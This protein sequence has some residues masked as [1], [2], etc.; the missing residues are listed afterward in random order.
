VG[1]GGTGEAIYHGQGGPAER[2]D[3]D[4]ANF[5]TRQV[6]PVVSRWL[7]ESDAPLVL[8]CVDRLAPIYR[9]ANTY[10][11]LIDG[12][13]SGSPAERSDDEL[14]ERAWQVVAPTLQ[15]I[16]KDARRKFEDLAGSDRTS[17]TAQRILEAAS[18][19]R[20]ETLFVSADVATAPNARHN[21]EGIV[22]RSAS[23]VEE[24]TVGTI[25]HG[26]QVLAVDQPPGSSLLAAVFRY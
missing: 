25:R 24:A 16:E 11:H 7:R 9:S 3:V 19:G 23:Q 4:V 13:V 6:D 5:F 26:G 22:S 14:R 8:A 12:H 10:A 17:T 18:Q 21:E 20:V 2:D 1:K 15:K